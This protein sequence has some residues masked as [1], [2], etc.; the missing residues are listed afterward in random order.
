MNCEICGR[1]IRG[2]GYTIIMDGAHLLVC[3]DCRSYGT[4]DTGMGVDVKARRMPGVKPV[5]GRVRRPSI[6]EIPKLMVVED[7]PSI[8]RDAR[9]TLGLTQK[10][11]AAKIN[12]RA[13]V[14]QKVEVGKLTPDL[15]LAR[16]LERILRVNL[17]TREEEVEAPR[18]P[19]G[20]VERTIGDIVHVKKRSG[21]AP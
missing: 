18:T 15:K 6:P 12:E 8:V 21:T 11:L 13:S 5:M 14:I 2:S 17:I 1:V 7:F 16:K 4:P 3:E 10:E 9:L 19:T 20:G